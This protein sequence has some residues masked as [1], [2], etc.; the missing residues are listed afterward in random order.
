VKRYAET[1]FAEF[2]TNVTSKEDFLRDFCER[3]HK[4][5]VERFVACFIE[6]AVEKPS[7]CQKAGEAIRE[8]Y[9]A[10]VMSTRQMEN[11]LKEQLEFAEDM[12]I[13]IPKYYDYMAEII[14]L[15]VA[16]DGMDIKP[17]VKVIC[18]TLGPE[19]APK[20]LMPLFK[21]IGDGT[22]KKWKAS[23]LN[24]AE[25]ASG[26]SEKDLKDLEDFFGMTPQ[27]GAGT[28]TSTLDKLAALFGKALEMPPEERDKALCDVMRQGGDDQK[29]VVRACSTALLQFGMRK[30]GSSFDRKD[31]DEKLKT[32]PEP[33]KKLFTDDVSIHALYALQNVMQEMEHPKDVTSNFINW[34]YDTDLVDEQVLLRWSEKDPN[35]DQIG[36]H[37]TVQSAQSFL[38][39]LKEPG[40]DR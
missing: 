40:G 22:L 24:I 12:V 11:V 26:M 37:M 17:V 16:D 6:S 29:L 19:T 10:R 36:Y 14:A 25:F 15:L 27:A 4:N 32:I 20:M 7:K 39:W 1:I 2:V 30:N 35:H 34:L 8:L 9:V 5:N 23:G 3:A 18:S 21:R 33:L 38:N 28:K 31:M 13:D